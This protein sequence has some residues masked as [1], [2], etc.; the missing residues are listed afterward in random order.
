[1]AGHNWI[2]ILQPQDASLPAQPGGCVQCHVSLGP[3]PNTLD[4]LTDADYQNVDCLMCHADGYKRTVAKDGDKFKMVPAEGVDVVKAAQSAQK[5]TNAMCLRC[6]LGAGGGPNAKHGV[7]PTKDTDVHMAAGIQ[8]VGCHTTTNHKIAGGADLKAQDLPDVKV[9]C[10]GCHTAT[11]HKGESAAVLNNHIDR[12]ACQVCHIPLIARDPT[13]PTVTDRDWMKS[14]LNPKT[15]LYGPTNVMANNVMPEYLWWNRHMTTPPMPVGSIDDPA[16]KIM[17]WKR[18]NY[19]Q[20]ADK[21]TNTPV[22]IKAGVYNV[23][24]DPLAAAKKG[25]ADAG[26]QFSGEITGVPETMV[27]SLNH[28]VAPKEQA[29]QCADCH[30]STGRLNFVALGYTAERSSAL[31]SLA[32]PQAASSTGAAAAPKTMPTTGGRVDVPLLLLGGLVGLLV[33]LAAGLSTRRKA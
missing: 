4:K 21:A 13:L 2:G 7:S 10:S 22:F 20:I 11:P 17:A 9:E 24:G 32:V 25:A 26:Q 31:A 28:Q 30:S 16:A 1:V 19:N 23:T 18:T 27:F 33:A 5:P 29:L 6:H 12:I 8:C 3:K 15:G 14:V